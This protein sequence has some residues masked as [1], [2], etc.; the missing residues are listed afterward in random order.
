MK[1]TPSISTPVRHATFKAL[2]LCALFSMLAAC[3]SNSP[4]LEGE[5]PADA[6]QVADPLEGFNRASFKFNDTIDRW[7]L[8]PV[9]KGYSAAMPKPVRLGVGNFFDNLG[10]ISNIVNNGLQ[11]K[12][13]RVANDSGR[14]LLNSTFGLLGLFDVASQAGLEKSEGENFTQTLATWGVPRGPYVVVPFL[15]PNT[16]RGGVSL[17]ADWALSPIQYVDPT[18][19]QIAFNAVDIVHDRAELLQTEELISGDRYLFV[20]EVYMQRLEYLE[21]DGKVEDDF[22]ES[23]EDDPYGDEDGF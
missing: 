9:A 23:F 3:A 10:E 4:Q 14:F 15:G 2:V 8:K 5:A 22:G 6:A 17:P 20:R 11:W 19:S 7:L 21:K 1:Q 12:W 16:L 18:E 13:K